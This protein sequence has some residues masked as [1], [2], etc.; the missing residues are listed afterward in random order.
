MKKY[1]IKQS[2][3]L[4]FQ[5]NNSGNAGSNEKVKTGFI[6]IEEKIDDGDQDHE[7]NHCAGNEEMSR[8]VEKKQRFPHPGLKFKRRTI[9]LIIHIYIKTIYIPVN[10][11]LICDMLTLH[12]SQ[13]INN[14]CYFKIC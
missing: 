1:Y 14:E 5:T 12:T 8:N 7:K 10:D 11:N 2:I 9:G 3:W 4:N 6:G 13:I